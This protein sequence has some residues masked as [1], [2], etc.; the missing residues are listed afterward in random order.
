MPRRTPFVIALSLAMAG[1]VA[2][3]ALAYR[4]VAIKVV[5]S[6]KSTLMVCGWDGPGIV[7]RGSSVPKCQTGPTVVAPGQGSRVTGDY[8]AT[9][10]VQDTVV[11]V[12]LKTTLGSDDLT[13]AWRSARPMLCAAGENPAIGQP[14]LQVSHRWT[15]DPIYG[16]RKGIW[17]GPAFRECSRPWWRDRF[18]EGESRAFSFAGYASGTA[19][20]ND[21]S[22]DYKEFV[23][24]ISGV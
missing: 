13:T 17:G 15:F 5:N 9:S 12:S 8:H 21:D 10:G 23:V 16:R 2:A 7:S 24:T 20:R 11:Q 14:S 19:K 1:A 18:A 3:P 6:T 4:G 22:S